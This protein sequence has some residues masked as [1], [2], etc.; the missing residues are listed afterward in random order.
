MSGLGPEARALLDAAR[1]GLSPSPAAIHRVRAKVGAS[2]AA[3]TAAG[4]TLAV[5]LSLVVVVAAT[6]IG[7]GVYA[8][9]RGPDP[10]VPRVELA[11][12]VVES[13]TQ[14]AVHEPA[15]PPPGEIELAPMVVVRPH[16]HPAAPV[17]EPP[18][19]ATVDLAREVEL[20][21]A[22]MAALKRGDPKAALAAVQRHA[23]ETRG[24]GQLAEDAAAIEVEALCRLHDP[25]TNS[26]LEAFD[27]RFPK[28]AQRSRLSNKCP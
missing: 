2:A 19:A 17:V 7:A 14:L 1:E 8:S 10:E 27:A 15:A 5:K 12:A 11:P 13:P 22:A 16:Q 20:V 21:D 3:G 26:R 18:P 25:T 23:L 24:T 4:A 6:A 9:K 28:S